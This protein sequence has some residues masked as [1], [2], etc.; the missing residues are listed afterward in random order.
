[1]E[2]LPIG[3]RVLVKELGVEGFIY[4]SA[5]NRGDSERIYGVKLD[6]VAFPDN[7]V[8]TEVWHCPLK[9]LDVNCC[10]LRRT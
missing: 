6:K 3:T 9:E 10:G 5:H 2:I 4:E 7:F 8:A 1:M